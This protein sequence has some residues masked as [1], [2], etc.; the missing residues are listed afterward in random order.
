MQLIFSDLPWQLQNGADVAS[1]H[2]AKWVATPLG[3]QFQK[4]SGSEW[5]HA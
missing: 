1:F 5:M 3:P 2:L 4:R